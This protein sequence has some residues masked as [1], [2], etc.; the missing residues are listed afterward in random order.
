VPTPIYEL[1]LYENG[2][3]SLNAILQPIGQPPQPAPIIHP[4]PTG[5]QSSVTSAE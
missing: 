3:A 1:Q 2:L 5:G 4:F